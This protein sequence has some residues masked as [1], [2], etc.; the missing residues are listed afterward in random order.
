MEGQGP[1]AHSLLFVYIWIQWHLRAR[2]KQ[3]YCGTL[4]ARHEIK[5]G[6]RQRTA[7]FRYTHTR[8]RRNARRQQ[9]RQ[10]AT[11]TAGQSQ[12]ICKS[13][14]GRQGRQGKQRRYEARAM[15]ETAMHTACK[16]RSPRPSLSAKTARSLARADHCGDARACDG[17]CDARTYDW[18]SALYPPRSF[19]DGG[20]S[21]GGGGTGAPLAL[22]GPEADGCGGIIW[23]ACPPDGGAPFTGMSW[24]GAGCGGGAE[25]CIGTCFG[26][27]YGEGGGCAW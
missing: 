17:G 3:H 27:S 4:N 25:A 1:Q 14:C 8:Q 12:Y 22:C 20:A 24:Y 18:G 23:C 26:C 9:Q 13:G 19:A 5:N 7:G 21:H 15:R 2:H 6:A 16:R 10:E 11:G